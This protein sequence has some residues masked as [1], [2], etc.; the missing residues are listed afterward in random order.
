MNT[1]R[2]AKI[3][4]TA[5]LITLGLASATSQADDD[6]RHDRERAPEFDRPALRHGH[7]HAMQ[8]LSIDQRQLAL[9]ARIDRGQRSGR[10]TDDEA[11]AL[12]RDLYRIEW[13][14]RR[15]EHDGRLER[16]EWRELDRLLDRLARDLRDELHDDD[17][18]GHRHGE[19]GRPGFAWR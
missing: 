13:L 9:K 17:R 8:E 14:E 19:Y 2:I 11:R 3:L 12:A 15:Y 16:G 6:G 1:V 5:A 18:R 4:S 7:D 10:L